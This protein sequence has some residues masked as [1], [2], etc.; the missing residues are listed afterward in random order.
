MTVSPS[1]RPGSATV[2][3]ES[4]PWPVAR[5]PRATYRLQFNRDFTFKDARRWVKYLHDLG[6]SDIYASPYLKAS[7]ES[8]HGYD[9]ADHIA[10][11]PAVVGDADYQ[12]MT[13]ELQRHGMGQLL[14]IVPNHMGI[15]ETANSWWMDVL[16]NG[17]S[18]PYATFFDISWQSLKPELRDKVLLPI[19]GDQYGVVLE[20]GELVLSYREGAFFLNYYETVLPIAP[21]S[22]SY[23]LQPCLGAL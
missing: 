22:Y 9:V 2:P 7:A 20:R 4:R 15:A 14:D 21:R 17:P 10:L 5:I 3:Q 18:S 12:A 23:I 6:I 1:A 11:N 16:E 13:T 19:L 8:T